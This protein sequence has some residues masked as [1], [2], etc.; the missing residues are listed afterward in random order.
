ME[1][2]RPPGQPP[3]GA[4]AARLWACGTCTLENAWER[5]ECL[6]CGGNRQPAAAVAAAANHAPPPGRPGA[7]PAWRLDGIPP[8]ARPDDPR[9]GGDALRVAARAGLQ[10]AHAHRL[11]RLTGQPAEAEPADGRGGQ[12]PHYP[13]PLFARVLVEGY[14]RGTYIRFDPAFGEPRTSTLVMVP[15]A[16]TDCL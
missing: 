7:A 8:L 9:T 3:A 11:A 12:A 10:Q 15:A 4:P 1:Q 16:N 6:A 13:P 2:P 5:P 14:G